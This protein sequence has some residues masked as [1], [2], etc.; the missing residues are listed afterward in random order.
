MKRTSGGKHECGRQGQPL[1]HYDSNVVS[2]VEDSKERYIM[3]KERKGIFNGYG[4]QISRVVQLAIV[5]IAIGAGWSDTKN[6]IKNI[7]DDKE[8]L[9]MQGCVPARSVVTEVAVMTEKINAMEKKVD[10]FSA[11]TKASENRI[12]K[13]IGDLSP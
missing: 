3:A 2:V 8:R 4:P 10:A 13:A 11:E 5:L 7:T 12:I 1:P 6:G 9:E